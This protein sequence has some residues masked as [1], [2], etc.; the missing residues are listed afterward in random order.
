V[1]KV[2]LAKNLLLIDGP[3]FLLTIK[4]GQETEIGLK[5][6]MISLAKEVIE[7][8]NFSEYKLEIYCDCQ[9]WQNDYFISSFAN[10]EYKII[11]CP[12]KSGGADQF[13]LNRLK[14]LNGGDILVVT[15]DKDLRLEALFTSAIKK[16]SLLGVAEFKEQI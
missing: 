12:K 16:I 14:E 8:N 9:N 2:G 5:K 1:L 15:D 11:F 4:N 6:L 10:K 13:I 7:G 3:N